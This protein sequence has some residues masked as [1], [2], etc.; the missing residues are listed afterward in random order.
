MATWI[1]KNTQGA[2][3][4]SEQPEGFRTVMGIE[5]RFFI[6]ECPTQPVGEIV[7]EFPIVYPDWHIIYI[8]TNGKRVLNGTFDGP[9][10]LSEDLDRKNRRAIIYTSEQLSLRLQ[11]IQW[12]ALNVWIPDKQRMLQLEPSEVAALQAG[13]QACV[14][15]V[16]AKQYVT[17]NLYYNL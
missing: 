11:V 1:V 13:I 8:Y 7:L 16:E 14:S 5:N 3:D 10:E 9:I 6:C 4:F 15:D 17:D 2:F 12:L